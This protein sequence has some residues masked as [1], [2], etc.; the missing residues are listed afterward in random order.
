MAHLPRS[1]DVQADATIE[2]NFKDLVQEKG[3]ILLSEPYKVAVPAMKI[4]P[5]FEDKAANGHSYN[6]AVAGD[7]P[8]YYTVSHVFIALPD[9]Q[10]DGGMVAHQKILSSGLRVNLVSQS[11]GDDSGHVYESKNL[12]DVQKPAPKITSPVTKY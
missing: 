5:P 4:A 10:N 3:W 9:I 7:P 6:R 1:G 2:K 12:F 8:Q 11:M